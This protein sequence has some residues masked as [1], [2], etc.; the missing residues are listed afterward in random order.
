MSDH[1][2]DY[3]DYDLGYDYVYVEDE[4]GIADDLAEHAVASPPW[5]FYELEAEEED[6]DPYGYWNDIEW[7]SDGYFE[8]MV[9]D[10]SEQ[11]LKTSEKQQDANSAKAGRKRKAEY[12]GRSQPFRKKAKV[13][14]KD[15]KRGK[16]PPTV[17]WA[18]K[19]ERHALE[20][21]S[22]EGKHAAISKPFSLLKDWRQKVGRSDES[23]G[24]SKA[25]KELQAPKLIYDDEDADVED[26]ETY[27]GFQDRNGTHE[28][29]EE[30]NQEALREG[31][32]A[33]LSQK[34]AASGTGDGMDQSTLLQFAMRMLSGEGDSDD[35]AGEL[36]TNLLGRATGEEEGS[37]G[38]SQ[39]LTERGVQLDAEGEEDSDWQTED[40]E[41]NPEE[42]MS[43]VASPPITSQSSH[44]PP[45]P[46]STQS[47]NTSIKGM[48]LFQIAD[49]PSASPL[50]PTIRGGT[51]INISKDS[52]PKSRKRK[53]EPPK[54]IEQA[55]QDGGK[56]AEPPPAKRVASYAAPT[57]SS[58][59]K[60][61]T[62]TTQSGK[63]KDRSATKKG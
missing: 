43:G 13:A 53:A 31:L 2:D 48:R 58:R 51:D 46:A 9:E 41:R 61:A 15:K 4:Y 40:G 34:L 10:E 26:E 57:A 25:V 18:P 5:T 22:R 63:G 21:N 32:K 56:L 44:R 16:S 8:D 3:D 7:A 27:E 50:A 24:K 12:S 23:F 29:D 55:D 54:C 59:N 38:I 45:T 14:D 17:V 30:M 42:K 33:A 35:I 28:S 1:D 52:A 20:D 11:K 39:W 37:S 36:A 49:P 62:A 6:F 60:T 47:S 19:E